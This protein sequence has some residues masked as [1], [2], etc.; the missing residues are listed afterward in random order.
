MQKRKSLKRK[1]NRRNQVEYP[2][3]EPKYNLRTRQEEIQDIATYV[4]KLS[5]KEKAWLNS[6]VE[7]E[8]NANFSHSGRK[9][10]KSKKKQREIY[11]RNNARNRD[12]YT[13]AK[14]QNKLTSLDDIGLKRED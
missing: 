6:F 5:D 1:I 2:G 9:F 8:I 4:H 13:R 14:A 3:L 10:T 7:E 11:T 12:I